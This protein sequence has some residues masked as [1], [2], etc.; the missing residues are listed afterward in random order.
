[1]KRV[2]LIS[3]L[4]VSIAALISCGS[5]SK[6]PNTSGLT[7]SPSSTSISTGSTVQFSAASGGTTTTSVYWQVNGTVGGDLTHGTISTSGLYTAPGTVP[8]PAN[9]TIT[10]VLTTDATQTATAQVTITQGSAIA[11]TIA[12][13]TTVSVNAS[14]TYQFV[15]TVANT[16]NTAVT[17]QVNS[18]TG[19]NSTNG[20]IAS[21]G[22]YTAPASVPANPTVTITAL[23]QADTTKTATATVTILPFSFISVTP[24][25]VPLPAGGQQTFTATA[26]GQPV[27]VTWSLS[28]HS[29][30]ASAC[31]SISSAGV[32]TAPLSPP[33]EGG[34][35]SITATSTSGS[36]NP[37]GAVA[38]IQF[39]NGSL[40]GQYA[41]AF[42]GQ[43]AAGAFTAAGSIAFDGNGNITGGVE[44]INNGSSS[45]SSITG[46]SY[47]IGTDG[48]GT[49]TVQTAA[50]SSSWQ[51]AL[52]NHSQAF[53]IR[54]GTNSATANGTLD[55][56][57]PTQFTLGAVKGNYALN[58]A[59]SNTGGAAGSLA[60]AGA[61]NADGAGSIGSG[62]LD[63]NSAGTASPNLTLSGTYTTPSSSG[64][65]SLTLTSSFGTQN[66]TYVIVD[67]THLKLM[68]TDAAQI[69]SGDLL[70]QPA[71]PFSDASS[72]GSFAFVF[73]GSTAGHPLGLGGVF[74]LDGAGNLANSI[75]DINDNGNWQSG[76]T[77]TGTY[78]VSDPATGRATATLNLNGTALQYVFYPR[79]GGLNFL[80][81]D[82]SHVASGA[83]Y[84]QSGSSF[85]NSSLQGNYAA[86]FTGTDFTLGAGEEDIAGQLVPNA[87]SAIT[88]VLDISD[89]ATTAPAT[90]VSGTYQVTS[91]SLGR[92]TASLQSSSTTLRTAGFNLYVVNTG[93]VLFLESDSNRVL[94]G[95]MQAQ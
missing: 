78:S 77:L 30:S 63:V 94:T 80:E 93:Q 67:A 79:P 73:A 91:S 88:G 74:T 71:G 54:S 59:G 68:G 81:I 37:G 28:C 14:H 31:G 21:T 18:V 24:A 25:N 89:G 87:G 66:F 6:P 12:P 75:A 64:S 76:M 60:M 17:W 47:H 44:D 70:E 42:S 3:L 95:M 35:V 65:G 56:Q 53:A 41:F 57:D 48:R 38:T 90:A 7:I 34:A 2:V 43:N 50:G 4:V 11:I 62:L 92:G 52:L 86:L 82:G 9:V 69:V 32:F 1:M 49:A 51:F 61:L 45:S 40:S 15:A 16:A 72:N 85:S 55:L 13:P 19:G 33:P 39:A 5:S 36:Y 20:T 29:N 46:G 27:A 58:L 84:A 22:L 8:S 26:N 23:A 10:A 83:A